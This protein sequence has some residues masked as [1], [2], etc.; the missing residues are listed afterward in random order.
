MKSVR[1][2]TYEFGVFVVLR[3]ICI[4]VNKFKDEQTE[5]GNDKTTE[6]GGGESETQGETDNKGN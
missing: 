4:F 1:C 6:A 2:G 3:F 5:V